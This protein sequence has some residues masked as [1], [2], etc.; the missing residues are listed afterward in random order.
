MKKST[1]AEKL[2]LAADQSMQ[3]GM[4]FEATHEFPD[5]KATYSERL[6][7]PLPMST[8]DLWV[9]RS[10]LDQNS[11]ALKPRANFQLELFGKHKKLLNLL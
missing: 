10:H 11:E 3:N 1:I 6:L 7:Y 2:L 9:A 8:Q 4:Q 5:D